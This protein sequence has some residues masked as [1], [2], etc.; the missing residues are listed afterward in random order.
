MSWLGMRSGLLFLNAVV[1]AGIATFATLGS[2]T[3]SKS[4]LPKKH[5]KTAAAL[6]SSV[7]MNALEARASLSPNVETITALASAY[8][9]QGQ[10][11]LACAV[12]LRAPRDIQLDPRVAD[13][14]A[15]A[16]F[17]RGSARRALAVVEEAESACEAEA[18]RCRPWQAAKVRQKAAFLK[19]VVAAGV[20]DPMTDPAAV[21]AAYERSNQKMGLVAMR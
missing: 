19:E 17:H 16:L 9:D 18:S 7:E 20:E 15:R 12:V 1:L 21:R 14:H 13:I 5:T 6:A 10:S 2:G 8:V 4:L 11:G 3:Q